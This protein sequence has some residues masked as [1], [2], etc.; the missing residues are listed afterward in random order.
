M[1]GTQVTAF[2]QTIISFLVVVIRS[3]VRHVKYPHRAGSLHAGVFGLAV[4]GRAAA[5]QLANEFLAA[6]A[7]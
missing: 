2:S 5:F 1:A 4:S 3:L 7:D 6:A